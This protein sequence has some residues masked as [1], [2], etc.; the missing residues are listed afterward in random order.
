[1]RKLLLILS[2]FII[3]SC[4]NDDDSAPINP[5]PEPNKEE[6]YKFSTNYTIL[7][8]KYYKGPGGNEYAL[9]AD[10]FFKKQWSFYNDPSIKTIQLKKDSVI[11]NENLSIQKYK[12]TKDGNN[13]LIEE[14]GKKI[15]LGSVD[16][17]NKSL[18]VYKNYQTSLIIKNKETNETLYNKGSKYGKITYNDIFPSVVSSP[19]QLTSKNEF[20]FWSNIEYT[21]NQ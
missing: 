7:D 3:F 6:F 10:A 13:I 15:I 4:N 21:F 19:K 20:V 1:M 18:S 12:F 8:Q 5:N 16:Q 14:G 17:I 2:L 9:E 11:I